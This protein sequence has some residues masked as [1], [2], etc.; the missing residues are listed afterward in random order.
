MEK[1]VKGKGYWLLGLALAMMAGCGLWTG[2]TA[3]GI[4][5]DEA[6]GGEALR[7]LQG[8]RWKKELFRGVEED[9]W[10]YVDDHCYL[11]DY[12]LDEAEAEKF[13][14]DGVVFNYHEGL[15]LGYDLPSS[16]WYCF[17]EEKETVFTVKTEFPP[18][19]GNSFVG[20]CFQKGLA[21]LPVGKGKTCLV[22]RTGRAVIPEFPGDIYICRDGTALFVYSD[23]GYWTWGVARLG[24]GKLKGARE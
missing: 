7:D 13:P 17:D 22:D 19:Q 9:Y 5:A 15:A 16:T 14:N 21:A 20:V 1:K 4:A 24:E 10:Q 11:N 2:I 23:E 12:L 8:V 6:Y 18:M 3:Y